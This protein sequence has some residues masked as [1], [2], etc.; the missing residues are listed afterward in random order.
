[1]FL[2]TDLK[3]IIWL[4]SEGAQPVSSGETLALT[5]WMGGLYLCLWCP[6]KIDIIVN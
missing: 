1:M 3:C 4:Q 2:K 5:V 6:R